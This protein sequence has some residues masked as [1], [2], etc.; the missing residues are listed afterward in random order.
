MLYC[1]GGSAGNLPRTVS[2]RACGAMLCDFVGCARLVDMLDGEWGCLR[3]R[4]VRCAGSLGIFYLECA[5]F[6]EDF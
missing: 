2:M 6:G 3:I 5:L 1:F 4:R